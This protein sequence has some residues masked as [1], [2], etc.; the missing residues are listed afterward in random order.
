MIER[1][2][3]PGMG[4]PPLLF[5]EPVF[6]AECVVDRARDVEGTADMVH[7]ASLPEHG[8]N[9]VAVVDQD[10]LLD[11]AALWPADVYAFGP[12]QG[13]GLFGAHGHQVVLY[14]GHQSECESEDFAID[15][16]VERVTVFGA[17]EDDVFFEAPA[18]DGHDLGEG[19]AQARNL[20]DDQRV[21]AVHPAEQGAELAVFVLR[22]STDRLGYP[23]IDRQVA[24]FGEFSDFFFLVFNVLLFGADSQV[25]D[26]R[27]RFTD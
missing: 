4:A 6:P 20:G 7:C 3:H 23:P 12:A 18:H 14:L 24:R 1:A 22:F 25:G 15:A 2:G 27:H 19:A 5:R 26:Y 21:A 16:V 10:A 17:V 9:L 11:V 13:E 8:G